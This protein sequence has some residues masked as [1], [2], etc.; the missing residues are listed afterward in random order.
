MEINPEVSGELG[1]G[2]RGG[3]AVLTHLSLPHCLPDAEQSESPPRPGRSLSLRPLR[4]WT[5]VAAAAGP[6]PR[7]GGDG[8]AALCCVTGPRP[9]G[10]GEWRAAP[11]LALCAPQVLSRLGVSP[12]WR[13]VDVLGFEEEALGAVPSP[14]CALLL[15]FPLT[16]QVGAQL[17]WGGCIRPSCSWNKTRYRQPGCTCCQPVPA[18]ICR[19]Q[20]VVVGVALPG[21]SGVMWCA[22]PW[23]PVSSNERKI[24]NKK[25][26]SYSNVPPMLFS[27]YRTKENAVSS[28]ECEE[29]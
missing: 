18:V 2:V 16:E 24:R 4:S 15:L 19:H 7:L 12:G 23:S 22:W 3:L 9:G 17:W 5:V 21:C 29:Q 26:G 14:A 20:L 13:F 11:L 8:G 25:K 6:R 10:C 28:L 1:A 27:V